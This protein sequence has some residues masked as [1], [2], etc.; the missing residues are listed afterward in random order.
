VVCQSAPVPPGA[1]LSGS[2][3]VGLAVGSTSIS[4]TIPLP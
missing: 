1:F 4:E 3:T 2:V